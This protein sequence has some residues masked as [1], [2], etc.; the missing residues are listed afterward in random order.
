MAVTIEKSIQYSGPAEGNTWHFPVANSE[1][2]YGGT[3]AV[4]EKTGYLKN[5]TSTTAKQARIVVLVADDSANA[6]GPAATTAAGSISGSYEEGSAVSGDKTVRV[7]Y[8]KGKVLLTFTAIAQSDVGKTVYATDNYTVDESFSG[9]V[10]IGTLVT[11][12][13]A[14]SGWV[15]LNSYY[16]ADGT[17]MFKGSLTAATGTTG[18]AVLSWANPT[19]ENILVEELFLD[20][21]TG[22]TGAAT[23]DFGVGSAAE[24]KDTLIDGAATSLVRVRSITADKGT[25]GRPNKATST[26]YVTGT[27]SATLAGLVGTYTIIYRIWE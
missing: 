26:Q 4:V 25:N 18:G 17:I 1:T 14:T 11:Y 16:N 8:T 19:G 13:S 7:C 15:D 6:T 27:A 23:V 2:I 3:L 9:G 24:S 21:T 10:K 20:I 5:L 12:V 22:S